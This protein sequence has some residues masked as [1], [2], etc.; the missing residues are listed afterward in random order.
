MLTLLIA[1]QL[2]ITLSAA[3]TT[4]T[5]PSLSDGIT[6]DGPVEMI[7]DNDPAAAEPTIP[8]GSPCADGCPW[9]DM[10]ATP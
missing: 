10:R 7:P 2:T 5:V 1:A 6:T 9:V 8:D 3:P 4:T